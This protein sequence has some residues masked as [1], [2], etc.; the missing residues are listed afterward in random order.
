LFRHCSCYSDTRGVTYVVMGHVLGEHTTLSSSAMCLIVLIPI[1]NMSHCH[2]SLPRRPPVPSTLRPHPSPT[3]C[4]Q[5]RWRH[6]RP[7]PVR[8]RPD[9][10]LPPVMAA[11]TLAPD[12]PNTPKMAVICATHH[13]RP[14]TRRRPRRRL[15][16]LAPPPRSA[17]ISAQRHGPPHCHCHRCR[18][19]P[20]LSRSGLAL[21]GHMIA[22][23]PAVAFPHIYFTSRDVPVHGPASCLGPSTTWLT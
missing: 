4:P 2:P 16:P 13:R 12:N 15:T 18:A 5:M 22:N 14:A 20:P 17:T 11:T 9:L 19:S 21:Q 3:D 1:W 23:R 8:H 6:R 7:P 10:L